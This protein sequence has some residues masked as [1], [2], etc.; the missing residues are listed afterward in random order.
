MASE[1]LVTLKIENERKEERKT[2][3]SW[4]FVILLTLMTLISIPTFNLRTI[5]LEENEVKVS[6]FTWIGHSVN[7]SLASWIH[8]LNFTDVAIRYVTSEEA[9]LSKKNLDEYGIECWSILKPWCFEN[10]T[11]VKEFETLLEGQ[12][13][14]S[15]CSKIIIDDV[16]MMFNGFNE[17][18]RKNFLQ[19]VKNIQKNNNSILL[20]FYF[21][22][23]AEL[24][25]RYNFTELDID[26]YCLPDDI[27]EDVVEKSIQLTRTL[28]LYL[29]VWAGHGLTWLN[30]TENQIIQT[31]MIAQRCGVSRFY[32]WMG[33]ETDDV[34]R[35]M[36]NSSLYNF[37]RWW[38][39]T[40]DLN[41]R[42][43]EN[44][45]IPEIPPHM[46]VPIFLVATLIVVVIDRLRKRVN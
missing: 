3:K 32:V 15:S 44:I 36:Y 11:L 31:Y 34:E 43:R 41:Y 24:C 10:A 45:I 37:R 33:H 1:E 25:D 19:G 16:Q 38:N 14:E 4:I 6:I 21:S 27:D 20:T 7:S 28:G 35:G 2:K 13:N 9:K 8:K 18:Q 17:T 30:V 12:I 26:V 46:L 23:F 40:S 39:Y 5:A 22:N 29:W 42:L